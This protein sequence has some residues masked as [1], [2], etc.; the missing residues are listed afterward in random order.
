MNNKITF[1]IGTIIGGAIGVAV[2]N[3][4]F[5]KK[6]EEISQEEI[7]S[8]KQVYAKKKEASAEPNKE[9]PQKKN[10]TAE[11]MKYRM[12]KYR[13][14]AQKIIDDNGYSEDKEQYKPYVIPPE[15]YGSLEGN[16]YESVSL[17]YYLDGVLAE[18]KERVED[19]DGTIGMTSLNHFGEYEDDSVF[20]RND[21]LKTDFEILLD[22]RTYIEAMR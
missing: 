1:L 11:P 15:E 16:G 4:Y 9:I 14:S 12:G 5:K 10:K 6:Y 8:V 17:T 19:I 21:A 2:T 7:D 13:K 20:V 22:Q 18:G 3:R